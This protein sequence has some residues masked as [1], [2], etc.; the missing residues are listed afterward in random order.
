[1][2]LTRFFS[3]FQ[4]RMPSSLCSVPLDL[5]I[6]GRVR[7]GQS[8]RSGIADVVAL[9]K[10]SVTICQRSPHLHSNSSTDSSHLGVHCKCHTTQQHQ[11]REFD[12]L[13]QSTL[14]GGSQAS[15][16]SLAAGRGNE[17]EPFRSITVASCRS[18]LCQ[19]ERRLSRL[20]DALEILSPSLPALSVAKLVSD[21][22]CG[23]DH[24]VTPSTYLEHATLP[25]TAAP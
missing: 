23:C 1:L 19:S 10:L 24:G 18:R 25:T 20:L 2:R 21:K 17:Q 16:D 12:A 7:C 8:S 13:L 5:E 22:V 3:S 14:I 4:R 6:F 15:C 9:L 11:P